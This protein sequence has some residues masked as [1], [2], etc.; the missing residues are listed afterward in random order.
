MEQ[1]S[2]LIINGIQHWGCNKCG[3]FLPATDKYGRVESDMGWLC[4]NCIKKLTDED[5]PLVFEDDKLAYFEFGG[6]TFYPERNFTKKEKAG[7]EYMTR[8]S[9]DEKLQLN[10]Q[11]AYGDFYKTAP[12]PWK[13]LY[14]CEETGRL[15][16]PTQSRLLNYDE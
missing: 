4:H 6:Y 10:T 13:D 14:R 11:Y 1:Q 3:N 9:V 12:K 2:E 16:C 15:Y 8:L 7:N 5:I